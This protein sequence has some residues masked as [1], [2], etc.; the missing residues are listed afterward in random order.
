ML[1][2][3][4]PLELFC[5]YT[6]DA[7]E[8]IKNDKN[9]TMKLNIYIIGLLLLS[10]TALTGQKEYV[11]KATAHKKAVKA[12]QE[13]D[14][15][16]SSRQYVKAIEFFDKAIKKEPTFLDA[17]LLR[18]DSYYSMKNYGKAEVDFEKIIEIDS[19]YNPRIYY[20]VAI[21]EYEQNKFDEAVAHIQQFL[22]L[23]YRNE[24]LVKMAEKQLETY[25]FAANAMANPVPFN[26][27][28]MGENINSEMPE[29]LPTI[30]AD[31]ET[32]LFTRRVGR[33]EDFY[34]SVKKD[35]VWQMAED[36]GPPINTYENEG[37]ETISADGRILVYTVCNRRQ[38]FGSCDLYFSEFKKGKWT[39]P[40]NMGQPINSSAWESQP[41]LS[42]DGQT[43]YF[44]SSR[45]KNKDI[46]KS[47]RQ[48][49]G[50]WTTPVA[51]SINTKGRE[52]CPFIHSDNETLYFTST[53][54]TGMGK[55]D[56][57][58]SRKQAD[59]TW[60]TPQ[61]LGYPINTKA[62]EGSLV[63]SL[64]GKTAYFAST[65]EGGFGAV[66][67]YSFEMPKA[68]RPTPTTY[69][70]IKVF[71]AVTK[72]PLRANLEVVNL[73]TS[74][75]HTASQIGEEGEVLI[76]LPMGK[77]YALNVN[78]PGYLF[79]SE[80]FAL[81]EVTSQDEPFVVKVYLQKIPP[82][83]AVVTAQPTVSSKPIVLNN[84][85]FESALATLE[86]SSEAELNKL[87]DLLS[88][89][90]SIRIQINGHTDNVG[91]DTDN[92][93]LS[94]ARAK[95]VVNFL[96]KKGIAANRLKYKG[97]GESQPVT[98]NETPE[99]RQKNRRTEF[100]LY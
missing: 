79:H 62:N 21:T 43:L 69:A 88:E 83:P 100:V 35:G 13:G 82:K 19:S 41:S 32:L 71:D 37:A 65:K 3:F 33:Q 63:V 12:Y 77:D 68:L 15:Y 48:G 7:R 66:D 96:I 18:A 10:A 31:G 61:N 90:E 26:P 34:I 58:L 28:N 80:N 29:Y 24:K 54:Y 87:Y 44:T 74:N 95:S 30:T 45:N 91:T 23:N 47:E 5:I 42:A 50:S 49:D 97:F 92:Q 76:C 14:M 9:K 73:T 72:Q 85:F 53:G 40:E 4:T 60:G 93:R 46:F 86:I 17:Y 89:N 78:R 59:G 84:V 16:N 81:K 36:L 8:D 56:L 11:T 39:T 67:L 99:G 25:E 22:D 70:V 64:D 27:Q 98:T 51:L 75:T 38:D 20:V 55:M 2:Y 1:L 52:E 6:N 94:E 57:F